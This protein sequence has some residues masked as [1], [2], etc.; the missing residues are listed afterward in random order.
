[1]SNPYEGAQS[2]GL[3]IENNLALPADPLDRADQIDMARDQIADAIG[4]EDRRRTVSGAVMGVLA[5]AAAAGVAYAATKGVDFQVSAALPYVR[6]AQDAVVNLDKALVPVGEIGAPLTLAGIAAVKLAAIGNSRARFIDR[7]SSREPSTDGRRSRLS[8]VKRIG[9]AMAGGALATFTASIATEVTN[10]PD[11][12][13]DQLSQYAP[14]DAMVVQDNE[15]MPMVESNVNSKMTAR[16]IQEATADG[17]RAHVVDLYL[18]T[19]DHRGDVRTTL[20][21]GTDMP[22]GSPLSW[23]PGMGCTDVPVAIDRGASVPVG[24]AF[25]MGGV[26][27]RVVETTTGGS[28]MNRESVVMDRDA[29]SNCLRQEPEAPPHAIVLDT[30]VDQAKQLVAE[31]HDGINAPVAVIS[32]DEYK[33]NSEAFWKDNV[34]PIT[35]VLSLVAGSFA[36]VAMGGAMASRILRN[37]RPLA[38]KMASGASTSVLR[39]AEVMRA[40]KDGIAA[41]VGAVVLGT[42]GAIASNALE[43]GFNAGVGFREAMIGTALTLIGT[44]G[45]SVASLVGL[46]KTANPSKNTR[47]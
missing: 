4:E 26:K 31:A 23:V 15:A 2:A 3:P 35:N 22:E 45:G 20:A 39:A 34:K 42:G 6:A 12:A 21:V 30:S 8:P 9:L 18:G 33:A 28:A 14:G 10:G 38:V 43:A 13:V 36:F 19:E 7:F 24:D 5:T 47:A 16:I 17:I 32:K 41:S 29:M 27:F 44:V 37:R 40:A 1:M 46:R 11:R 25:D